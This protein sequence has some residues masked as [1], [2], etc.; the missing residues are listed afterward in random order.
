MFSM[1]SAQNLCYAIEDNSMDKFEITFYQ[2]PFKVKEIK[3]EQGYFSRIIMD[4][5]HAS[6]AVGAPELPVSVKLIEIPLCE[7]AALHVSPG[8][9]DIVDAELYGI[10]HPVYPVQ[11][12]YTKSYTGPIIFQKSE[13]IYN[14]SQFYGY[15]LVTLEVNGIFRNTRLATLYFSPVQYNPVTNQFKIYRSAKVEITYEN[16]DIPGTIEMKNLHG[17]ALFNGIQS[18]VIN[19]LTAPAA[20]DLANG[21]PIKYL[22]VANSMF[23]GYFDDFVNWKKEK[24]FLVEVAYTDDASVGT[25]TTSI[26]AFIKSKYT[27]ATIKDPAPSYVLLLGDIQQIPAFDGS[28]NHITDLYYFTW[29]A[30]DNLPD[31]YY[32]RMSAQTVDQLT[33]QITKTLK[34]EKLL[35]EDYSFL[36]RAVLVAGTDRHWSPTHANGQVNYL[37]DNYVNQDY[38]F[39]TIYKHN[40]NC[41]SQA[42]QI[43]SEISTGT[44]FANYTA[45]CS[46][47]G[48]ADPSF[49]TSHINSMANTDMYGLMIGNCCLS[50]KF[51]DNE[52]FGEAITRVVNKGAVAYIGGTNNTLW[53]DDYNWAMGVRQNKTANP[54]YDAS[55]LGAYDRLFHTH[56]EA[57]SEWYTTCGSIFVAGN[58]AVQASTSSYKTYYW[59][60]YELFGDPSLMPY[61]GL[62]Q[63]M[64]VDIPNFVTVGTNSLEVTVAPYAY[65]A[66]LQNQELLAATFADENGDAILRFNAIVDASDLTLAASAQNYKHYFHT[67]PLFVPDGRFVY[68]ENA[69]LSGETELSINDQRQWNLT[70]KN[71]GNQEAQCVYAK[72]TTDSYHVILLSDSFYI[73]DVSVDQ[74]IQL[75]DVFVIKMSDYVKDQTPIPF[76]ITL[77]DNDGEISNKTVRF[78]ISAPKIV[79]VDYQIEEY[80]S[81]GNGVIE[82]GEKVKITVTDKNIGHLGTTLEKM[83]ISQYTKVRMENSLVYAD[84]VEPG[85]NT[86]DV[87]YLQLSPDIENPARIP[88]YYRVNHG[89]YMIYDTL[90]LAVGEVSED[91]ESN[92]FDSFGWE[93]STYPWMTTS[94]NPYVGT[95]CAKSANNLGNNSSSELKIILNV[96]YDDEISYYRKVSSESDYDH[97]QFSIDGTVMEKKSGTVDWG[98]SSFPVTAG[99]HAFLFKY[100]KDYSQSGGS[101]CAWIDNIYLPGQALTII[102]D[103]VVNFPNNIVDRTTSSSINIYPNPATH[104]ITISSA[105]PIDRIDIVDV[106]GRWVKSVSGNGMRNHLVSVNELA[107]GIY[108]IRI[109]SDNH[110]VIVKKIVKQ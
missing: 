43:R 75:N 25:T 7:D 26:A 99:T 106:H 13:E 65:V 66:L 28:E 15:E 63:T 105:N 80:E 72:L 61:L 57:F 39:T 98:Y 24:G 10:T 34:Y 78:K 68:A 8:D 3:T 6:N 38:G 92:S 27:A 102:N 100:S 62:P 20:R 110:S 88:L 4:D 74:A 85:N 30:G 91:F 64:E 2:S 35:F 47:S 5:Y 76:K 93:N 21:T 70:V 18:K 67:I 82:P 77:F 108:L 49:E 59:E 53:N 60:I 9:F 36:G 71:I 46:S 104:A 51:D 11:P 89:A 56:D 22:I 41:S 90:Y 31:C 54:T 84:F 32:G 103:T 1:A 55:N 52:C 97:F 86:E 16:T 73:G 48:W 81:N 19:P 40:Y 50:S 17:N 14:T 83:M 96:S 37:Y 12:S 58:L 79:R 109:T 107:R 94:E 101:D 23:R 29:T 45:H 33:A 42:A 95:Y 69:S 87:F 44:G